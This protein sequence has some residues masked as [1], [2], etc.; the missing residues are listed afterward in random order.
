MRVV[1]RKLLLAAQ[2]AAQ[3]FAL[4]EGHDEVGRLAARAVVHHAGVE[5]REDV[6]MLQPGGELDL[7]EEPLEPAGPAQIRPDDLDRDVAAV[8]EVP[9]R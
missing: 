6:G 1:Y 3:G 2:P 5:D 4:D 7:A 8:A 9:A